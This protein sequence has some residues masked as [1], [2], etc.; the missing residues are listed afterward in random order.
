MLYK[1]RIEW[2]LEFNINWIFNQLKLNVLNQIECKRIKYDVECKL[3]KFGYIGYAL[4][5]RW[6]LVDWIEIHMKLKS[7]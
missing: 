6:M 5:V 1:M 3:N 2:I 7:K 4:V